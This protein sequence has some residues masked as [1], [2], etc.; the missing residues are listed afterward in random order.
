MGR[1]GI[2]LRR[3]GIICALVC[4][5]SSSAAADPVRLTSLDRRVEGGAGGRTPPDY[6]VFGSQAA[7]GTSL[8]GLFNADFIVTAEKFGNSLASTSLTQHTDVSET[9]W[10]GSG[11]VDTQAVPNIYLGGPSGSA[12]GESLMTIAFT[13]AEPMSYR[14]TGTVIGAGTFSEVTFADSHGT[15]W[16]FGTSRAAP[17]VRKHG[18]LLSPGDYLF[19]AS[20]LSAAITGFELAGAPGG[21]SSWDVQFTLTD[22]VPEPATLLLFGTGAAFLARPAWR[23]RREQSKT[24]GFHSQ[25]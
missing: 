7:D 20:A 25:A 6:V 4:W 2:V 10:A 15:L 21:T 23:R 19:H 14:F 18:G 8:P 12:A 22:P 9:G 5:F 17:L 3:P 24:G 11:A 13:L 1:F 16:A